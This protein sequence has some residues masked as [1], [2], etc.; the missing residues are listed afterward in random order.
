M[1]TADHPY[2]VE[3]SAGPYEVG[4]LVTC[5]AKANPEPSLQDY[6]WIVNGTSATIGS[7]IAVSH[8]VKVF[9]IDFYLFSH[10]VIHKS[11]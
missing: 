7:Q 11:N 4:D 6:T 9:T 1:F 3:I 2:D 5:L 10:N 8:F